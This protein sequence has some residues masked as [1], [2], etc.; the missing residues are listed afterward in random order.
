MLISWDIVTHHCPN[1]TG[2][3]HAGAHTA[4][5]RVYY[6]DIPTKWIEADPELYEALD[7]K[8]K[9]HFAATSK[10][11]GVVQLYQ[12]YFRA[13]SSLHRPNLNAK[14]RSDTA[15]ENVI[16]VPTNTIGSIQEY[17]YNFLN[18][19]IQGNEYDALLGTDI[20]QIDYIYTEVHRVDTYHCCSKIE[21]IDEYLSSNGFKRI[22]TLWLR[23]G[24]GDALYVRK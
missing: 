18:L 14:R 16:S 3:I 15:T 13:A 8:Q 7:V 12:S 6:K 1:I 23:E 10:Q 19:D 2:I 21:Q 20:S 5:E 17:G 22:N 11:Q 24:W 9:Y 4:E